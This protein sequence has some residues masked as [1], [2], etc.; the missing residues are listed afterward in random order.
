M[1][2]RLRTT[3]NSQDKEG[4]AEN[5]RQQQQQVQRLRGRRCVMSKRRLDHGHVAEQGTEAGKEGD[6]MRLKKEVVVRPLSPS[7][8]HEGSWLKLK[9]NRKPLIEVGVRK[10]ICIFKRSFKLKVR[11]WRWEDAEFASPHN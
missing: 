2:T 4:K 5:T 11:R 9:S 1:R 3:G 8:T 6:D 10:L 7:R